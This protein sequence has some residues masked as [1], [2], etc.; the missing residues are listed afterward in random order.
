MGK[1]ERAIQLPD[2]ARG[3]SAGGLSSRLPLRRFARS[4]DGATAIEYALIAALLS[5]MVI[6]SVQLLTPG[7]GDLLKG[8]ADAFPD[9]P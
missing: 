7:V 8:A 9:I 1:T 6:A 5:V 3:C 4:E 2:A